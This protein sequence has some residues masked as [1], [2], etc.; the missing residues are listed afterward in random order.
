MKIVIIGAGVIG[1]S[2]A[3]RLAEHGQQVTLVDR[4][5]P[6]TG[7]TGSTFAWMNSNQKTPEDYY[8]LNLAGMRMHRQLRDELGSTPWL[9]DTG[10]VFWFTDDDD[11]A[12]LEGR[13]ARLQ[14]WGYQAEWID[15]ATLKEMEPD[16]IPESEVEHMAYFRDEAWVDGPSLVHRLSTRAMEH[17]AV[18]RL[19]HE[20]TAFERTGDRITGVRFAD[21]TGITADLVVNCAGPSAARIARLAGRF[22]PM[23]AR[24]G[25]VLRVSNVDGV[26]GRVVHAP[27]LHMRPD[28]DG[29]V[30]LHHGDADESLI[31]REPPFEWIE[32]FFERARAYSPRFANARLSG[33]SIGVR[34]IPE[35]NRTS[36]GPVERI[37]G[38]AEIVTH[39]GITLGP[40]LGTLVARQIVDGITDPLLDPFSP[41][42]FTSG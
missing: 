42:R 24:P 4:A 36:A 26:L 38:Y 9:H 32:T 17:G 22:L 6:G 2:L 19:A 37:P 8:A 40:L 35:D 23:D 15:R 12:E 1:S 28:A 31:R 21:G 27:L 30:M 41:D 34:P 33:W 13:V 11:V 3:W 20:V 18:L 29:L 39:S 16:L 5:A 10:N 25:L 14:S 7:A